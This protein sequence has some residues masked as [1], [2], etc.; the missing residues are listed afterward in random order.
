MVSSSSPEFSLSS[1]VDGV[2]AIL[3]SR[4]PSRS[5]SSSGTPK[6]GKVR[7]PSPY[8]STKGAPAQSAGVPSGRIGS[9]VEGRLS[10]KEM[11]ERKEVLEMGD[12]NPSAGME[13]CERLE[14]LEPSAMPSGSGLSESPGQGAQDC[15]QVHH[16][17]TFQNFQDDR[18]IHQTVNQ[19][20]AP[21]SLEPSVM[22]QAAEAVTGARTEAAHAI[23]EA[24]AHVLE[25]NAQFQSQVNQL[26]AQLTARDAAL[27]LAAEREK[28]LNSRLEECM[29]EIDRLRSALV[30]QP[31][32]NAAGD[33]T[34]Q[35][36]HR[37][38]LIEEGLTS[39]KN[40]FLT[41][42]NSRLESSEQN[43]SRLNS[44]FDKLVGDILEDRD[45]FQN[46]HAEVQTL[47]QDFWWEQGVGETSPQ[48]GGFQTPNGT[49]P[50]GVEEFRLFHDAE[51]HAEEVKD[52]DQA[53]NAHSKA[54][55]SGDDLESVILRVK[56]LH[57]FK[58]PT[59][60]SDA[61][62]FRQWKNSLKL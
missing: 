60:P 21:P 44:R 12:G 58:V 22:A 57:Y 45:M 59:L 4:A 23:L 13:V 20:V 35:F 37:I 62:A 36:E 19:Y 15:R 28:F 38:K 42:W 40:V 47:K 32:Q 29:T 48:K 8:P 39:L 49:T 55:G 25:N 53:S 43:I 1:S 5:S 31:G 7:K 61:G 9:V 2:P 54:S 41:S 6:K 34:V 56:D 24:R 30:S 27:S 18:Q 17:Q 33:L 11:M 14:S 16:H 50:K 52:Q 51:G 46:L 10:W 26:K 3:T